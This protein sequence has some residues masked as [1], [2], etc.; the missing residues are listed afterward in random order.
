MDQQA[1]ALQLLREIRAD[2]RAQTQIAERA[3]ERNELFREQA[4]RLQ[5]RG[6]ARIFWTMAV[7]GLFFGLT[8][9]ACLFFL[10]KDQK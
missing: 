7:L 6:T 1:E 10:I 9:A 8:I 3:Q 2:I 4:I 5:K